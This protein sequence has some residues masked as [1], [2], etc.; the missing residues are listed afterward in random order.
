MSKTE[1]PGHGWRNW[2]GNQ[3]AVAVA[4]ARPRST[5]E[6]AE[7][8]RSAAARGLVVKPVGNGH[9]FS[10]TAATSGVR[11]ELEHL[12]GLVSVD[13]LARLARV[14]AGMRLA[15]LNRELARH[16]LALPNLGDIDVQS[17][18]GALATGTHGT[19]ARYG[20]LS[21]FVEELELVTGAGELVR[22]SARLHPDVF[23]AARV[24]IG[25]VGIITEVTL[26]CVE[27]FILHADER[28]RP[29]HD[30]LM[31]VD[32][33]VAANDHFEFYWMPYT[34]RA[35]AKANNRADTDY[36]PRGRVEAW[37]KDDFLENSV[38][39]GVGR[40]CRLVPPLTPTLLR[41]TAHLFSPRAYTER[42]DLV[43]ISP[44]RVRFVEMEYGVPRSA[45][46]EA[47]DGLRKIISSLP[48][49]VALPVEVR[50]TAGDDIWLSHGYGRDNAYIAIH[51]FVGMPYEEYFRLFEA[52]CVPL[53]GRPHWAKVHY[54]DAAWLSTAYP[55]FGD[56]LAVRDKLDPH[57]VFAN[58][59]THQVLGP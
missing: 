49:R 11:V 59:Y 4:V 25:A 20:C 38:I 50:F 39:G 8:V 48:F 21:T 42:S 35:L 45:L 56:F 31:R 51:Q 29:L 10:A 26:R 16:D 14:R 7:L 44:R 55:H 15:S 57:R 34:E 28:P 37:F 2:A 23:H 33:D 19:G 6:V 36:A 18:S 53:G 12:T 9:S 30:V 17:V 1:R 32:D 5:D 52:V 43:F 22:C 40:L 24:G 13:R 58:G 41:A 27:A 47:F 54:R 46:P 3:R